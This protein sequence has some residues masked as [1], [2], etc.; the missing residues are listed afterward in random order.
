MSGW[1]I[2]TIV[3]AV[4]ALIPFGIS[5][6]IHP[7]KT[8]DPDAARGAKVFLR[9]IAAGLAVVAGFLLLMSSVVSVPTKTVG[10]VTSFGKPVGVL[11]N[12][13]HWIAPWQKVV[14]FD[15]SIQTLKR[16]G[17][18]HC[19]TV[20]I[21]NQATA[22]VDNSTRWRIKQDAAPKLYQDYKTF[23]NMRDSLVNRELTAVLNSVFSTYD[24]LVAVEKKDSDHP[25]YNLDKLGKQATEMLRDRVGDQVEINSIVIPLIRYDATTEK[26]LD[27]FQAA[28][29]DTRIS[30]QR[31]NTAANEAEANNALT[32][33]LTADILTSKCLDLVRDIYRDGKDIP[34]GFSCFSGSGVP[35]IANSK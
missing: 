33:S 35:V 27:G 9:F 6:L 3:F 31:R 14:E 13:L 2:T 21:A 23:S 24:P 22:C 8:N 19:T 26:K 29:A 32:S 1:L 16:T 25:E 18:D 28:L 30:E 5:L 11:S 34:P 12:G 17:K 15:A 7:D 4:L 20:R 10:V